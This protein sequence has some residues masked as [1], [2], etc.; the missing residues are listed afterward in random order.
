[1][2]EGRSSPWTYTSHLLRGLFETLSEKKKE[3][4][5]KQL[6]IRATTYSGNHNL[7]KNHICTSD[8]FIFIIIIIISIITGLYEVDI[9]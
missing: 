3:K 7:E 4:L 6:E 2:W 5:D 9:S 8:S 1:M